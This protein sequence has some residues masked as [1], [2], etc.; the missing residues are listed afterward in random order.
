[1]TLIRPLL[2]RLISNIDYVDSCW[3]YTGTIAKNGYG[4]IGIRNDDGTYTTKR[5]HRVSYEFF[6]DKIPEGLDLD[7]T[8]H[9]AECKEVLACL[10]RRCINPQHL[11]PVTRTENLRRGYNPRRDM[12][13][14]KRGHEF[15]PENTYIVP[16]TG[17][18]QCKSCQRINYPPHPRTHCKKGHP[19]DRRDNGQQVCKICHNERNRAYHLRKK[20]ILLT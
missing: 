16:T 17:S 8:C 6:K 7:H 18:R 4:Q 13:H 2:Y 12:T 20:S 5:A 15:T 10:H 14:C 1:M 19:F 3:R 9:T 11:E